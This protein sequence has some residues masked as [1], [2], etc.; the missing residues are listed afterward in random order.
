[1]RY[2]PS[3]KSRFPITDSVTEWRRREADIGLNC[4]ETFARFRER[5][6]DSSKQLMDLLK[7]KREEGS[8]MDCLCSPSGSH[9]VIF[10]CLA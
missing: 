9:P 7:R 2:F 6:V 4:F 1:M 8:E 3:H 10:A 5:I